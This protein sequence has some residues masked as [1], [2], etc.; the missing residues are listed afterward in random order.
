MNNQIV[1]TLDIDESRRLKIAYDMGR[2]DD[3]LP[4]DIECQDWMY[5]MIMDRFD[6]LRESAEQK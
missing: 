4:D 1:L 3:D 2:Y 5:Q 6:E